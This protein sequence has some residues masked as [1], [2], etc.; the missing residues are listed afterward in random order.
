M[1]S[2]QPAF[3]G[4]HEGRGLGEDLKRFEERA[5]LGTKAKRG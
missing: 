4:S 1:S 5:L 2:R 3:P